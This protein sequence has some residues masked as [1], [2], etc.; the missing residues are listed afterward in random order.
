M[1]DF[2]LTKHNLQLFFDEIQIELEKNPVLVVAIQSAGTGK[3]GMSRLWRSWMATTAD[4][5]A[6]NGVAM[7]LMYS[8][9]GCQYGKRPFNADDAHELFTRQHLGVDASG[10]RLSWAKTKN[11][12]MRVATKGERWN[13]MLKHQ[14]WATERG[15]TLFQPRDSEFER[16]SKEQTQ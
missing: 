1:N 3:W 2:Q 9:E 4:F 13:A 7:P 16:L 15:I 14:I 10:A 8:S 6:K 12:G 11:N 5:M